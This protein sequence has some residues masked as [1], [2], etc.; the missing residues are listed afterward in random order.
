MA[1][2]AAGYVA[3]N[4]AG[5][6]RHYVSVRLTLE[7]G[8]TMRALRTCN[9]LYVRRKM[10]ADGELDDQLIPTHWSAEWTDR[11]SLSWP[12]SRRDADPDCARRVERAGLPCGGPAPPRGRPRKGGRRR[13]WRVWPRDAR[14]G[15]RRI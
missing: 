1:R 3:R 9:W 14:L 4:V 6:G 15:Q 12:G 13:R 8:V 10:I 11:C 2:N 5:I 7:T